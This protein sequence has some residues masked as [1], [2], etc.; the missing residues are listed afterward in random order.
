MN[1]KIG[2]LNINELEISDSNVNNLIEKGF[3]AK[4]SVSYGVK[5]S[6]ELAL[7]ILDYIIKNK[8]KLNVHYC[9][10]TLKDKVQL[11]N[12][13]KRRALNIKKDYDILSE[14][15]MLKRGA[16]YLNGLYPGFDYNN[17]IKNLD[18]NIKNKYIKR[19]NEIKNELI[20]QYKINNN[21][22]EV[23]KNKLRLLTSIKIIKKIKG[24]K[25]AV[26][27]EYPTY[28]NMIVELEFL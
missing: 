19:L 14:E 25:R 17:K 6:E 3:K 27:E 23:D 18:I 22:I 4:N 8:I 9:T 10:T 7:E 16:V 26:V 21:M 2:F 28:D 12:R 15:G 24:F 1:G 5:G 11:A 13:I 20:K